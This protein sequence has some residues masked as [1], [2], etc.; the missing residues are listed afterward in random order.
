MQ[1][2]FSILKSIL[3]NMRGLSGKM[4]TFAVNT[5]KIES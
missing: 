2:L 3:A 4:F 5:K 1:R